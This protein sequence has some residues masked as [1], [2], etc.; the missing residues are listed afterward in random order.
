MQ[1]DSHT[2]SI[3]RRHELLV[4]TARKILVN[5]AQESTK[6]NTERTIPSHRSSE[7]KTL[8]NTEELLEV[9]HS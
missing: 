7:V 8:T 2:I 5:A 9:M 1:Q 4:K 3:M 6:N